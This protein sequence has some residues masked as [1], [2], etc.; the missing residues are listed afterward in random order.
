MSTIVTNDFNS[1]SNASV[2]LYEIQCFDSPDG[3]Y[4]VTAISLTYTAF[5]LPVSVFVLYLGWKQ[6]RLLSG[7]AMTH[8]DFFT[9]SMAVIELIGV[10]VYA[11]YYCGSYTRLPAM[12]LLGVFGWAFIWPAQTLFPILTCVEHY[13]AVVHPITYRG[14]RRGGGVRIRNIITGCIW[15]I[16]F[17]W[18]AFWVLLY[19]HYYKRVIAAFMLILFLIVMVFCSLSVLRVLKHPRP[20]KVGSNK[21]QTDQSKRR[22]IRT[23]LIIMG[24]L[25]FNFCGNVV[26]N[27][28]R[29]STELSMRCIGEGLHFVVILPSSLVL[30]LL[31]LQ[32]AGKLPN[33]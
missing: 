30:P 4:V 13:L 5:V 18:G 19:N 31:F 7:A 14:L 24:V 28:I 16:C 23:I 9:Y 20:G 32:R 11:S 26:T 1:I 3:R 2:S 27:I 6:R 10:F 25:W 8:S 22:A 33:C 21:E 12:L 15:L 17:A 29:L